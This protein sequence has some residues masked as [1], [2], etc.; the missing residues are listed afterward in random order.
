MANITDSYN[1]Y[2]EA[3]SEIA[4]THLTKSTVLL[5]KSEENRSH[6]IYHIKCMTITLSL[7]SLVFSNNYPVNIAGI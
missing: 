4:I 1:T 2:D 5:H 6:Q 3:N 7:V